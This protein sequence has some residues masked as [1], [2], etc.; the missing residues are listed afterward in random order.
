MVRKYEALWGFKEDVLGERGRF[1]HIMARVIQP[2]GKPLHRYRGWV[3]IDEGKLYFFG[4]DKYTGNLL[5]MLIP[6]S[7]VKDVSVGFDDVI[8][9]W[10]ESRGLERPLKITYREDKKERTLYIQAKDMGRIVYG[11]TNVGL[12]R[13]L[14]EY[15]GNI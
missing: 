15:C 10:R 9:R 1:G 4:E 5:R 13:R 14:K 6:L 7:K 2:L 11:T 8:R 12:Y 3:K